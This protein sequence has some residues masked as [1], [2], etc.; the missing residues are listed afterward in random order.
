MKPLKISCQFFAPS[1]VI[2]YELVGKFVQMLR[3]TCPEQPVSLTDIDMDCDLE[4]L[5]VP[6]MFFHESGFITYDIFAETVCAHKELVAIDQIKPILTK[7][8]IQR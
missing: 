7:E 4:D 6:L 8:S 1:H 3:D 5:V 2:S